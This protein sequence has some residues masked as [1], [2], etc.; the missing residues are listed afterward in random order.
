MNFPGQ[1]K[2]LTVCLH[3]RGDDSQRSLSLLDTILASP[4]VGKSWD[5]LV[6]FD[7]PSYDMR[8]LLVQDYQRDHRAVFF[9][10]NDALGKYH[11]WRVMLANIR[12]DYVLLLDDNLNLSS[13]WSTRILEYIKSNP[14]LTLCGFKHD[15]P[16]GSEETA[17]S[18]NSPL[19]DGAILLKTAHY[20]DIEFLPSSDA[21]GVGAGATFFDFSMAADLGAIPDTMGPLNL[22]GLLL[23]Q[24]TIP[25]DASITDDRPLLSVCLCAYGDHPELILRCLQSVLTE[26][27]LNHE[28]EVILGCNAVSDAVM[29]EID[30]LHRDGKISTIIR[31]PVN[32]NKSGMQRFTFRIARAPYILSLDDDMYFSHG[33]LGQMKRAIRQSHPFEVA[34][35]LHA[36]SNRTLWSGQKKPYDTYCQKKRWWRGKRPYGLEVVFPAGQ[37]FLARASFLIENDYPDLDMRIDW[38]DV[39]LGDMVTQLDGTQIWFPD[40]LMK[41]I[42]IDDIPSRGRHGGG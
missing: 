40:D 6:A 24:P 26:P 37:C 29:R 16:S 23:Q 13:D 15:A 42:T 17:E 1:D 31:S 14:A 11:W 41:M 38:D 12:S 4:G 36:L 2:K 20:R 28:V 3:V 33:W 35:R 7:A 10:S 5:L 34:G 18:N 30:R 21:S 32:F 27:E 39:L 9:E 19:K 25:R 8:H 22:S